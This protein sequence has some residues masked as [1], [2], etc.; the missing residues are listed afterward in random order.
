MV[1]IYTF[2]RLKYLNHKIKVNKKKF[3]RARNSFRENSILLEKHLQIINT[4]LEKMNFTLKKIQENK[5]N[6]SSKVVNEYV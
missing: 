3:E 6:R 4:Q 1:G 2:F 5:N